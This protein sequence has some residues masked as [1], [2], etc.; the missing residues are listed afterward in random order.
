MIKRNH[1]SQMELEYFQRLE[2]S[3]DPRRGL[4]GLLRYKRESLEKMYSP[5]PQSLKDSPICCQFCGLKARPPL[6][7][8]YAE[9]QEDFCCEKYKELFDIVVHERHLTVKHLEKSPSGAEQPDDLLVDEELQVKG[10]ERGKNRHQLREMERYD[11]H[12]QTNFMTAKNYTTPVSHTKSVISFR[13]SDCAPTKNG[14]RFEDNMN[15][16]SSFS[17]CKQPSTTP[18]SFEFGLT[19]P[20]ISSSL[21]E[22]DYSNGAKFLTV[23]PDGSSQVFYPSGN[24]AI[25]IIRSEKESVCIIHDDLPNPVC[26]VRALFKSD[27]RATCYHENGS[28][29]LSMDVWG[30]QSLDETG[31]RLRT[32]SWTDSGQTPTILRPIFLSLNRNIGVRILG[33]KMAFVSFLARGQQARF[34]VGDCISSK[35]SMAPPP[36]LI[37]EE[38]LVL[39]ACRVG[40]Y[41]ALTQLQQCHAFPFASTNLQVRPPPFIRS[42]ARKLKSLSHKV[43]MDET[44]KIFIQQCLQSCL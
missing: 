39:L 10:Q 11:R 14:W 12:S 8:V 19:H 25:I 20:Q 29:W 31:R 32:W 17:L 44:N 7:M 35:K 41:M 33:R 26:P 5:Q 13:L 23:L 38:E 9:M 18:R 4:P 34:R 6:N 30:G 21:L 27:G 40:L 15:E 16:E 28:I 36:P 37:C 43:Q 1:I 3:L 24:L 2:A 22:K 42:L